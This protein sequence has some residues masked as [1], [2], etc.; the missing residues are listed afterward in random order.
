V[1][2]LSWLNDGV[3]DGPGFRAIGALDGPNW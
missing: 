2:D 3:G 1:F